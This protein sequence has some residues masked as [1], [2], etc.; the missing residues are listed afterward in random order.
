MLGSH[1]GVR[2]RGRA[3]F[4]ADDILSKHKITFPM[5][6]EFLPRFFDRSWRRELCDR[7]QFFESNQFDQRIQNCVIISL[8]GTETEHGQTNFAK[9][10]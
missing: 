1:S 4:G 8:S 5:R 10:R 7:M 9:R 6:F 3:I 2:G